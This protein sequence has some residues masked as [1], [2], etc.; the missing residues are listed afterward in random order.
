[1]VEVECVVCYIDYNDREFAFFCSHPVCMTC[2]SQL[3]N[4]VCPY[5]RQPILLKRKPIRKL[6]L[7]KYN[8]IRKHLQY[9]YDLPLK[10]FN[11]FLKNKYKL[12]RNVL[13][14]L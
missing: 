14:N 12:L 13:R 3:L 10:R 11:K 8:V 5:C 7:R 1:M 6:N 2:Y 4:P 9:K